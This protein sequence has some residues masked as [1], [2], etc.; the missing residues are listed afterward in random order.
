[1]TIALGG[2]REDASVQG[3]AEDVQNGRRVDILVSVDTEHD[4]FASAG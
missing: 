4:L 2:G 3:D 1:M